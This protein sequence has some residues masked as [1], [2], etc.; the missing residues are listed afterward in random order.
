MFTL[1]EA[2]AIA[3]GDTGVTIEGTFLGDIGGRTE[4]NY[5]VKGLNP[6]QEVDVVVFEAT[7]SGNDC[8]KTHGPV[9]TPYP[10]DNL[11]GDLIATVT[12]NDDGVAQLGDAQRVM[13][14]SLYDNKNDCPEKTTLASKSALKKCSVFDSFMKWAIYFI[15]TSA[16]KCFQKMCY[17]GIFYLDGSFSPKN[18]FEAFEAIH[19]DF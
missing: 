10:L 12:A 7:D 19:F 8:G 16:Q 4:R 14:P 17:R 15:E 1:S 9:F 3:T 2:E 6:G 13:G 11:N 5:T 18:A